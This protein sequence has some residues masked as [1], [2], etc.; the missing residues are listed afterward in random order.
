MQPTG[1]GGVPSLLSLA[2]RLAA[3]DR[4][5]QRAL[6]ESP[7][8]EEQTER[9]GRAPRLL[10]FL[11]QAGHHLSGPRLLLRKRR[12]M[13]ESSASA[14]LWPGASPSKEPDQSNLFPRT[15]AQPQGGAEGAWAAL[16]CPPTRP[17]EHSHEPVQTPNHQ[18][19]PSQQS[20]R[21]PQGLVA[22]TQDAWGN[23]Q[24]GRVT[25]CTRP[26]RTLLPASRAHSP[27][28]SC[29]VILPADP[30]WGQTWERPERLRMKTGSERGR[31]ALGRGLSASSPA[32]AHARPALPMERL[33]FPACL[34]PTS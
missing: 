6:L 27:H 3:L 12:A 16:S 19:L 31:L 24:R 18:L 25:S 10:R 33:S 11:P 9:R 21:Q 30:L 4:R 7:R 20:L 32:P 1:R 8:G 5:R 17:S 2:G 15:E 26:C 23:T 22:G 29:A 13:L 28:L 14:C 34:S